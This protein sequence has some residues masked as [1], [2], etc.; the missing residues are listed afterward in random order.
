MLTKE[1][2]GKKIRDLRVK[3]AISQGKLAKAIGLESHAA[4]SDIERGKT[5]L[6]ITQLNKIADFFEMSVGELLNSEVITAY[7]SQNRESKDIT[8]EERKKAQRSMDGFLARVEE[9]KKKK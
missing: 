6:K 9:Y 3:K 7:V 8:P 4:V 1:E 2:I 5:N